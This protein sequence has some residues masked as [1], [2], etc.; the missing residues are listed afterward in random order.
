MTPMPDGIEIFGTVKVGERG[1][2]VIPKEA[3]EMFEISPGDLLMIVGNTR[4]GGIGIIKADNMKKLAM[5]ILSGVE[6][7]SED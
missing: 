7:S 3:R 4:M 2:I 5:R 1:Q 6:L